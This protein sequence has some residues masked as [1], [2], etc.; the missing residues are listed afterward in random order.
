MLESLAP[1]LPR[2]EAR[3][4]GESAVVV[5][6]GAGRRDAPLRENMVRRGFGPPRCQNSQNVWQGALIIAKGD[7]SGWNF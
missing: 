6:R 7:G 2:T 3:H 4:A 1:C 5:A